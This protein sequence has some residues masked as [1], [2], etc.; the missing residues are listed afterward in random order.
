MKIAVTSQNFRTVTPHAGRT[1]RFLIFEVGGGGEAREK[2]APVEVGRLDLPKELSMHDFHGDGPHPLDA[3]DVLIAGS[4]G[5]GFAQRMARRGITL[6]R[7]QQTDPAQAVAA[8]LSGSTAPDVDAAATDQARSAAEHSQQHQ[9]R[10]GH[11]HGHGHGHGDG[12]GEGHC[13]CDEAHQT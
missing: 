11:G 12:H 5:E 8:Y 4:F 9:G 1:R 10:G 3:V 13:H 7:A 2:G 6:V